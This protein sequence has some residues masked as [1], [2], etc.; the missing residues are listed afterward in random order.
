MKNNGL[1]NREPMTN[2]IS[3]SI[4]MKHI[5]EDIKMKG[6]LEIVRIFKTKLNAFDVF[7]VHYIG[8]GISFNLEDKITGGVYNCIITPK[9]KRK[10]E[11]CGKITYDGKFLT[12]WGAK[13]DIKEEWYCEDCAKKSTEAER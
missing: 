9:E 12:L 4:T 8:S 13:D 3:N 11:N 10:C 5:K 6:L 2:L 7:K 1:R